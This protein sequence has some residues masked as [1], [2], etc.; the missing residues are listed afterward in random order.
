MTF[1]HSISFVTDLTA[2]FCCY[3]FR[4][5][6]D[7]KSKLLLEAIWN[8]CAVQFQA[9]QMPCP[10]TGRWFR[11]TALHRSWLGTCCIVPMSYIYLPKQSRRAAPRAW[12]L[13]LPPK[14]LITSWNSLWRDC[15]MT[16]KA[17][18]LDS[19]LDSAAWLP[20]PMTCTGFIAP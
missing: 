7:I 3:Q 9:E 16:G 10:Q 17:S 19:N 11:P 13:I 1:K 20:W 8:C 18:N 12:Q 14:F 4:I 15:Q 5:M 6:P 2:N